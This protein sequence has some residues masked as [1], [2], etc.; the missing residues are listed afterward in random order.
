[1]TNS[2]MAWW[3][4]D[5]LVQQ[6]VS[7]F[8]IAPGSRST[9]LALAAANHPKASLHI[10]YD[11]RGLGFLALGIAKAGHR[12]AALI[13]TSGT[14]LGNLFPSVMEAYHSYTPLI[15]LTADRPPELQQAGANQTCDQ[16]G[17]F[18]HFVKGSLYLPTADE[19]V[20]ESYV[21][22]SVAHSFQMSLSQM[23][24]FHINWQIREPLFIP[25]FPTLLE[26]KPIRHVFSKKV[27]LEKTKLQGKGVIAIGK[28]S[29]P[30][31]LKPILNL[32]AKLKWPIFADLLSEARF[33][34]TKE[35]IFH[36]DWILKKSLKNLLPETLLHF[37]ERL[38]SKAF[39]SWAPNIRR[40]HV[41]PWP[42][43]QDPQRLLTER[44]L[45]APSEF[46]SSAEILPSPKE[47]L[48]S[49]QAQDKTLELSIEKTFQNTSCTEPSAFYSL[50]KH[51]DPS[52]SLYLGSGM[53][54]RDA[55]F[56]FFPKNTSP[57]TR[58]FSNRGLSGIDG[59]IAT[60]AGISEALQ[61]PL[62]AWIG[63]Q[64]TLY[65]LNSLPLLKKTK[66]PV[67]LIISNNFGGG[68]FSHLPI[69]DATEHF[70]KLFVNS[71]T[72]NFQKIAEQFDLPYFR[73]ESLKEFLWHWRE[74]KQTSAILELITCRKQNFSCHQAM[75]K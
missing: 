65:D 67:L 3:I 13:V 6:G 57:A 29:D 44:I 46:C 41:S 38:T 9:P 5:Q 43:L 58:I 34:P 37:G 40:I 74:R 62:I 7:N 50:S 72:W 10:H 59:N 63:D 64:A 47:W 52:W 19:N 61:K 4:I 49:W 12:P 42:D 54:I 25:P 8:C 26:G 45:V 73:A 55:N 16:I 39:L 48:E 66:N 36:F 33:H 14:A 2:H 27:P 30:K 23:G 70:E 60:A 69:A 22:S 68:I 20:T 17:I 28:L 18:G 71:H 53:P 51:F 24:P 32:A 21:R 1:M 35:Q 75:L 15:L 31:D 56:F 11:E